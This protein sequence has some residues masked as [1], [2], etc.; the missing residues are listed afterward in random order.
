MEKKKKLDISTIVF[1]ALFTILICAAVFLFPQQSTRAANAVFSF[2]MNKF[3]SIILW[4]GLAILIFMIWL[5]FSKYKNIPLGEE[6]PEFS[7]FQIFV[8]I[9]CAAFGA[10][11]MYWCMVE[12]LMYYQY[13]FYGAAPLSAVAAEW[14]LSYNFMH[15]GPTTWAM[16][17]MCA[18]PVIYSYYVKKNPQ[19]K[20]SSICDTLYEGKMPAVFGKVADVIYIFSCF[21]A[22][23]ISLGISVP[24]ISRCLA[25]V[26]GINASFKMNVGIILVISAVFTLS[27]YVGLAKGMAKLSSM[28]AWFFI[29]FLIFVLLITGPFKVL[30]MVTNSLG[31]LF[32]NYIRVSLW[33]DPIQGGGFPQGWT[34]FYWTYVLTFAPGMGIFIARIMKGYKLKDVVWISLIFGSLGCFTMHGIMESYALNVELSGLLPVAEMVNSG[35]DYEAI[36]MMIQAMPFGKL[37]LIAFSIVAV[38]FMATTVDSNSFTLSTMVSYQLDS[39][40][41]PSPIL[42]LMW[43]VILAAFPLTLIAI[44]APL[45]TLKTIALV[46]AIPLAI[47]FIIMNI[48]TVKCMARDTPKKAG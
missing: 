9:F 42:R 38:L 18:I 34:A 10:S 8:M 35:Q 3:C 37:A 15:W 2:V 21:G 44:N 17:P 1:S 40:G 5:G 20:L 25:A 23:A 16:Y 24:M 30:D 22:C 14:A 43:C 27:S 4:F 36:V 12:A 11:A 41:N 32:N 48:R 28:N 47:L 19:L 46:V 29:I 33:T 13:S 45:N 31:L 7:R 6:K 26:I 39:Q